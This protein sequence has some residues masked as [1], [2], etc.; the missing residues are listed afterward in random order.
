MPP[1][2]R[3]RA[4]R[5]AHGDA[6]GADHDPVAALVFCAP[7]NVSHS[8]INGRVVD[9]DGRLATLELDAHLTIHRRLAL[10]LAQAARAVPA[11][12]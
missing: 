1:G 8:V 5:G 4:R 2:W 10:E 3:R 7:S 9:D 11:C 12:A 6:A